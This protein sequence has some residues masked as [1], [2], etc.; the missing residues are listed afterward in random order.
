MI[1][2]RREYSQRRLAVMVVSGAAL[3]LAMSQSGHAQSRSVA[4][5]AAYQGADRDQ[6]LQQGAKQEGELTL[7]TSM[8]NSDSG[9]LI[10]A[11]EKKFGVKVKIW[12][13]SSDVILQRVGAES[14]VNRIEAD[15]IMMDATGLEPLRAENVLQEV[16][17]PGIARRRAPVP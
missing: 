16:K 1:V 15:I 9:A 13:A 8:P 10:A 11:F 7:Y 14:K 3:L 4:D 5:I 2:E 12:G 6:R 17:S